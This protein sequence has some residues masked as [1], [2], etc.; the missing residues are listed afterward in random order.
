M[1]EEAKKC[2]EQTK[3]QM[4]AAVA[5][6]EKDFTKIRAGKASP[7]MVDGLLIDYYGNKMPL[8]QIANINTPDPKTLMIQP[9][10]KNLLS[11][12]EK[13]I[14]AANLGF[15]PQNDG[16]IIRINVPPLTEERRKDLVKRAKVDA[17]NAKVV[18]RGIRR[19]SNEKAR[20]LGKDGLSEDLVKGLESDIQKITDEYS[21]SVDKLLTTKEKEIMTI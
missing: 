11:T 7:Q 5:H 14:H 3:E 6:L 15:T 12:I 13:A 2:V 17:E 18:V 16:N 20:K 8:S 21:A 19:D 9:W 10:E 1:I 4:K